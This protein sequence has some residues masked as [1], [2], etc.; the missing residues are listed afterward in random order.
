MFFFTKKFLGSLFVLLLFR[1]N[2]DASWIVGYKSHK[3]YS[4]LKSKHILCKKQR[5]TNFPKNKKI[6]EKA[7][8]KFYKNRKYYLKKQKKK[9]FKKRK[10]IF[11][12]TEKVILKA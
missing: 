3:Y 7:D 9:I 8:K 6:F 10:K 2:S 4:L 12:K 5:K 11:I 1:L